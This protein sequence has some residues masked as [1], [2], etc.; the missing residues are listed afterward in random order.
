MADNLITKAT[1]TVYDPDRGGMQWGGIGGLLVGGLLAH[2]ITASFGPLLN[3]LA[4]LAGGLLLAHVGDSFLDKSADPSAIPSAVTG[5]STMAA[6]PQKNKG[7][8]LDSSAP[9]TIMVSNDTPKKIQGTDMND[10][11]IPTL[12]SGT[13]NNPGG[14]RSRNSKAV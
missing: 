9:G 11:Y 5:K 7:T 2:T 14:S 13:L 3:I 6:A 10:V 1:K 4:T 8:M 12:P